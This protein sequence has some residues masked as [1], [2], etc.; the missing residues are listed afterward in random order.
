[1]SK[2]AWLAVSLLLLALPAAAAP[3]ETRGMRNG[4]PYL[5]TTNQRT[6]TAT[7]VAVDKTT[8]VVK[9]RTEAG[10]T[11]AVV[12]GPEVKNL[13]KIQL[14][15]TVKA[16]I[17]E[18]VTIEIATGAAAKDTNEVS[19]TSAK[20]EEAPHGTRMQRSRSTAAIVAIDTTAGTA[21]LKGQDGNTFTVKAKHKE[22]LDKVQVGDLVVFTVTKS[23][24]ASVVKAGA[25]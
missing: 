19:A 10:D 16:D 11:V 7:V 24:A 5:E 20:P 23:V 18:Q 21:T 17:K 4:K 12:A 6:V 13:A 22:N 25:K 1:M 3:Q 2:S 8:R 15:D 14:A 9:L